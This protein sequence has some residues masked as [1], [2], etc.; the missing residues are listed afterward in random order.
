MKYIPR[1]FEGRHFLSGSVTQGKASKKLFVTSASDP[2]ATDDTG[3]GY[4]VGTTWVNTT[5]GQVFICSDVSAEDATWYGQEGDDI[6]P[7]FVAQGTTYGW[8]A[9]G[10]V[11]PSGN[12]SIS[13]LD[14][15]TQFN[16]AA[17]TGGTDVGNLSGARANGSKGSI[18]SS[19]EGILVG[20]YTSHPWAIHDNIDSFTFA[21]P[22]TIIKSAKYP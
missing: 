1:R 3:L 20:G 2:A 5:S 9:G 13:A 19:T 11:E 7:P 12:P 22:S 15:I 21:A 8:I 17:P 14:S 6:N 10:L 4:A 18:R 16:F